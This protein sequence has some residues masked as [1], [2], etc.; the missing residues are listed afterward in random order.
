M[1]ERELCVEKRLFRKGG[2]DQGGMMGDRGLMSGEVRGGGGGD[3]VLN[4]LV[5]GGH[6]GRVVKRCERCVSNARGLSLGIWYTRGDA[7]SSGSN[8][9]FYCVCDGILCNS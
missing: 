3:D 5:R 6:G 4:V 2:E 1:M 7:T 9:S 8:Q